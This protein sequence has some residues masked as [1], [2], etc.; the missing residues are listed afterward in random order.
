MRTMIPTKIF[1]GD[2]EQELLFSSSFTIHGEKVLL[3]VENARIEIV[4]EKGEGKK[5]S[6]EIVSGKDEEPLKISLKNFDSPL[7]V[8]TKRLP[9]LERTE[10][11]GTKYGVDVVIYAQG[12]G[13]GPSARQLTISIFSRAL[14]GEENA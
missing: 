13:N 11:D 1:E 5:P 6:L 12:L 10:D 14:T 2:K 3:E 9:I 4:F 7:G 8:S